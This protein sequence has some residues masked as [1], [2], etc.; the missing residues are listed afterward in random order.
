MLLGDRLDIKSDKKDF[1]YRWISIGVV[2]LGLG[3]NFYLITPEYTPESG[4]VPR[5]LIALYL[6]FIIGL[7]Y[8]SWGWYKYYSGQILDVE[9]FVLYIPKVIRIFIG[10]GAMFIPPIL[11]L[12]SNYLFRPLIF[13]TRPIILI[14]Y[15]VISL[16]IIFPKNPSGNWLKLFLSIFML[17]GAIFAIAKVFINVTDFPFT[18]AWSEGNRIWDY[19]I[20]FGNDR[21]VSADGKDLYAFIAIGRQFLW[22]L[23]FLL[24]ELTIKQFRFWDALVKTAP[25]IIFGI[26]LAWNH[27]KDIGVY[28]TLAFATWSFL[29][30]SQGP[31]FPELLLT[32]TIMYIGLRHKNIIVSCLLIMLAGYLANQFRWTWSYAPGLW[33]GMIS[34]ITVSLP[35][36]NRNNWRKL[37]RPIAYGISGYIGGQILPTYYGIANIIREFSNFSSQIQPLETGTDVLE[38]SPE[39]TFSL[40]QLLSNIP[41]STANLMGFLI[42]GVSIL[43]LIFWVRQYRILKLNQIQFIRRTILTFVL[44]VVGISYSGISFSEI[45]SFDLIINPLETKSLQQDLLW[46]RLLPNTTFAPGIILGLLLAVGPIIIF[47]IWANR[48]NRW[49]LNRLQLLGVI[50]PVLIFMLIGL[51]ASVKIGGGGDLHNADM[52]LISLLLLAGVV[53]NKI[54]PDLK[55]IAKDKY[56]RLLGIVLIVIPVLTAINGGSQ[57]NLPEKENVD[58][59]LSAVQNAVNDRKQQGE[60]LFLDHRQ[61]LTFGYITDIPMIDEYEKKVL[62]DNATIQNEKYFSKFYEDIKN[63]RF[64]LIVSEKLDTNYTVGDNA[65]G[66]ENDYWVDWVSVPILEYYQPLGDFRKIDIQLL[67]PKK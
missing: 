13:L 53:W 54:F 39:Q 36:F 60:V 29:Y 8:W 64:A 19:S 47:L 1:L 41:Y 4:L 51:V 10:I 35:G 15:C 42:M 6:F 32:A 48:S 17:G 58:S 27:K 14:T 23:P 45:K 7:L 44:V 40:D 59:V 63:Q 33:A 18:L 20:L 43:L 16:L 11:F 61:L 30:L 38:G 62:M 31:I 28:G 3:Y 55:E 57:L 37:I 52:F 2:I 22:G 9:K 12:Y 50:A 26:V 24:S 25:Y 56:L 49:E 46:D 5:R 21:Y 66:R 34:L 67:V 65:F